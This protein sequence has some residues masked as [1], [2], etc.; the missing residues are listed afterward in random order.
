MNPNGIADKRSFFL[1]DFLKTILKGLPVHS[2][3]PPDIAL[4]LYAP[5]REAAS[6]QILKDCAMTRDPSLNIFLMT[7]EEAAKSYCKR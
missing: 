2:K 3:N 5:S 1:S 7:E 4:Y 6:K